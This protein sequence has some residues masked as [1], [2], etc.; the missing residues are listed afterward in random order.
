VLVAV[1]RVFAGAHLPLD[2][3]GGVAIGM[4]AGL[5]VN[6][7]LGVPHPTRR[8]DAAPPSPSQPAP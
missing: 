2:V 7:L 3:V 5:I 6:G 4:A 8:R 1:G